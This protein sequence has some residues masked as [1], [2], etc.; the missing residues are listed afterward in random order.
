MSQS[1]AWVGLLVAGIACLPYLLRLLQS[2]KSSAGHLEGKSQ[3]VSVLA[4]GPQQRVVTVR[5]TSKDKEA[6][7][8]LGV[9]NAS[10][11][12]LHKWES[13]DVTS[14]QHQAAPAEVLPRHAP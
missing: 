12:C 4:V 5:V 3:V 13:V 9:T 8:V 11:N 10:V 14:V 7:L 6:T 2:R 1:W